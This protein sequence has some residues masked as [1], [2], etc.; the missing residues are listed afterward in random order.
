MNITIVDDLILPFKIL[1]SPLR[2]FNYIAQKPSAKGLVS[3]S[4]LIS[5]FAAFTIYISATKIDLNIDG[6]TSFIVTDA[7][8]GW[9]VFTLA[10]TAFN[11]LLYW[12]AFAFV[13]T[14]ASK[15]VGGKETSWRVL[16]V[17]FGYI[18]SVFIVLYAVR[19]STYLALPSIY[20][21]GLSSWPPVEKAQVDFVINRIMESWGPLFA[22][23][24][25][26]IFTL[27]AF[28]WL[29]ILGAIA[30]RAFR[31]CSWAKATAVSMAGF[32]AAFVIFGLP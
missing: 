13:L 14:L 4:A 22:Y 30:V 2:A 20:F 11:I 32:F 10:L 16:F 5:A 18:P 12:L 23:Q 3:I 7:F 1:I 15:M 19:A 21:D 31:E 17:G 25:G 27:A 28:V 8:N 26:T 29:V 24:L 6:P 9:F